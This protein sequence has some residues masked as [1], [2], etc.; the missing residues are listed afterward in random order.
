[1]SHSGDTA[2]PFWDRHASIDDWRGLGDLVGLAIER[3]TDPV[4]GMHHAIAD[5]GLRL[6]G[7]AA[8]PLG[9]GYRAFTAGVYGS[10]R[11]TG[12]MLASAVGIGAAAAGSHR[13]V[14]R[15]WNSP[16]GSGIRSIANAV[17]GDELERR[18]SP[19]SITTGLRNGAGEPI[20]ANS[21]SLARAFP[22]PTTRLAVLLHG[23]GETERC[24]LRETSDDGTVN[25][26]GDLLEASSFT[27]L[28]VRYNSGRH[29]SDSGVDLA[30]LLEEIVECWP[31]AVEELALVGSSMGGLV[32]RAAIHAG[33]A[34]GH[35]WAGLARNVVT[36][37]APHL[38]APLEKGAHLMTRGLRLAATTR[39]LGEFI[40]SRS[41]GVKD[42][43]FG[44]IREEDWNG[45]DTDS[46]LGG[47][48]D[49]MPLPEGVEQHFVAAVVTADPAHP[50]GLLVGD[51]MVRVGSGTGRGPRRRIEASNVRVLGGRHHFRLLHD[52][53]VHHQVRDW[54]TASAAGAS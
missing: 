35:R 42:L 39:P 17:W 48:F 44:A 41:A 12:S 4:E 10:V 5:R 14:P 20:S 47:G 13:Q 33:Q 54:L 43:R 6:A 53:D 32:V 27:P 24:W 18:R 16:G 15:L 50:L 25:G 31:V 38:G 8:A 45:A 34:A 11:L 7:S 23:L 1:M 21:V 28:L 51:L 19:L 40:D 29:V 26:L 49:D 22:Q 3:L 36:I 2:A 30:A 46:L 9:R 37:G 52:R